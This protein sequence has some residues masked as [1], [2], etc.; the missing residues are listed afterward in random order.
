MEQQRQAVFPQCLERGEDAALCS[1]KKCTLCTFKLLEIN[2]ISSLR[3]AEN[4]PWL[5]WKMKNPVGGKL[6]LTSSKLLPALKE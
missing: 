6:L 3:E 4:T 2:E 1:P 5:I